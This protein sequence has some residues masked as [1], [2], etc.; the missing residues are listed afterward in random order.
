MLV[1]LLTNSEVRF[2]KKGKFLFTLLLG[3]IAST[4]SIEAANSLQG[5][6]GNNRGELEKKLGFSS[7]HL[8]SDS[9]IYAKFD[10]YST[11][12]EKNIENNEISP[13][14]GLGFRLRHFHHGFDMSFSSHMPKEIRFINQ[15]NDMIRQ[16]EIL[17]GEE[18]YYAGQL[19][20]MYYTRSYSRNTFYFGAGAGVD[21][22]IIK[23]KQQN[24]RD[25]FGYLSGVLLTGYQFDVSEF[26][27]SFLQIQ[28]SQPAYYYEKITGNMYGLTLVNKWRPTIGM[29]L[30]VGF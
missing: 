19:T 29:S 24:Y 18:N 14:M 26:I 10:A 13:K 30:G 27:K 8:G 21:Q 12:T 11:W 4:T 7:D 1:D 17:K 3:L 2:M 16:R 6:T 5:Y 22:H 28:V 9:M 15:I 25:H 20:Y 23:I